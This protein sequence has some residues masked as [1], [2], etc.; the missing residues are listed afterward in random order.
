MNGGSLRDNVLTESTVINN[1]R[2]YGCAIYA[3][4]SNVILNGVEF[5]N[6]NMQTN[7]NRGAAIYASK[8]ELTISGC[9]FDGNGIENE[10]NG[11]LAATSIIYGDD[12]SITVTDSTF[13]NN[14]GKAVDPLGRGSSAVFMLSNSELIMEKSEFS[15][16]A[17]YFIINDDD[18]S[19]ICVSESKFVD[20]SAGIFDGDSK[21]SADSYFKKC[22]FN[23]NGSPAFYNVNTPLSLYEC[24][25]GNS[26]YQACKGL[27]FVDTVAP[28]N[29]SIGSV[30]GEGS[31]TMIVAIVAVLALIASV[32][33]IS[34]VVDMK[35][36]LVPATAKANGAETKDE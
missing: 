34:L 14:G 35:K 7:T 13:M 3:S 12:C 31:M 9:T 4:D 19:E 28:T 18:D 10:E 23:N 1:V 11:N 21:T 36:K 32:V 26:T 24:D 33:S 30:F 5:K 2:Y 8:N 29:T 6:N 20:N 17:T 15:N 16:N 27:N 25:M 22:S